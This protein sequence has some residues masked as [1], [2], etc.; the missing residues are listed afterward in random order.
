MEFNKDINLLNATQ[1][2]NSDNI[3]IPL[4][5]LS[6]NDNFLL[7]LL[8]G[9]RLFSRAIWGNLIDFNENGTKILK[10]GG[11]LDTYKKCHSWKA[12]NE[13]AISNDED[14]FFDDSTNM[15][16]YKGW[17][18]VHPADPNYNIDRE[19]WFERSFYIPESLRGEQLIFGMKASG[20]T[21]NSGWDLSNSRFESIGIE[22]VGAKDHVRTFVS[23]G[24]WQNYDD[25]EPDSYGPPM[26]SVFIPFRTN[27]STT[28]VRIKIFRTLNDGFLHIDKL[29]L[30]GLTLPVD[31]EDEKIELNQVDINN[32]FDFDNDVV[33]FNATTVMGH[34]VAKYDEEIPKAN[35]LLLLIHMINK[36]VSSLIESSSIV[37]PENDP[38]PEKGII[39][40]DTSNKVYTVN[41][42]QFIPNTSNPVVTLVI[43]NENSTIYSTAV[44]DVTPTSFKIVLSDIPETIGYKVNWS[45]NTLNVKE[46][47]DEINISTPPA[48]IPPTPNEFDF[49]FDFEDNY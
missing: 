48:S 3:N 31:N 17:S 40:C 24:P 49:I 43:P 1:F 13:L 5:E 26:R 37:D 30:G 19:V 28:K 44:T 11:C 33:K 22:I 9:N 42:Q 35:D 18:S 10:N 45:V 14:I 39:E 27:K 2:V 20:S 7:N 36:L 47:I 23:C 21:A 46:W 38:N 41:T 29:F 32:F 16:V 34:T 12:L 8:N 25:F 15:L 4:A 6:K